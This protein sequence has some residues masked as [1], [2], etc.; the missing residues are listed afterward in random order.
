MLRHEAS[1]KSAEK[2][3][4]FCVICGQN[5]FNIKED[6]YSMTFV[7]VILLIA[8]CPLLITQVGLLLRKMLPA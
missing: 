2:S 5:W 1:L 6:T 3:A 8:Y 4:L 7:S